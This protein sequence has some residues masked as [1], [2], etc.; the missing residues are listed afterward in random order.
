MFRGASP[1]VR[2]QV[3][4]GGEVDDEAAQAGAA[5]PGVAFVWVKV[6]LPAVGAVEQLR[7]MVHVRSGSVARLTQP[8]KLSPP[9]RVAL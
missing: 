2:C 4:D 5:V 3:S 6:L 9:L 8:A 7:V 1:T